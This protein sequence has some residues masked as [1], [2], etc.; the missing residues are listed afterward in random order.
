MLLPLRTILPLLFAVLLGW[1][2]IVGAHHQGEHQHSANI[3]H[4]CA[5]CVLST[6][7]AKSDT[8]TPTLQ[9]QQI[10]TQVAHYLSPLSFHGIPPKARAPP[11]LVLS[12]Y[13]S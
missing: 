12:V 3:D 11:R 4:H 8:V 9:R 5:L 7:A 10:I 1:Q 6:A 2:G 13:Y